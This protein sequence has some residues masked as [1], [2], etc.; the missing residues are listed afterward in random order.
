[1]IRFLHSSDLHL[2]KPFGRFPEDVRGRLKQARHDVIGRLAQ[3]ARKGGASAVLLAGDTFDAETPAPTVVRQALNEIAQANDLQ[4]VIMPGN[5]DSLAASE[6]WRTIMQDKPNNVT[7]ALTPEPLQISRGVFVLP[8][9]CTAR[10]P[11]RDLTEEMAQPTPEGALRIG[12]G[13]G[14]I[15]DFSGGEATLSEDGGAAIIPPDRAERSGLDYLALGD[16]HGQ[17]EVGKRTW[18]SG[19]PER[20]SFKHQKQASANLVILN[21]P[22]AQ[23]VVTTPA[24]GVI[25]WLG[26][27]LDL[28]PED[29]CVGQLNQNLPDVNKRRDTI[30]KITATGRIG[31]QDKTG[32]QQAIA[33]IE[34][35]FLSLEQDLSHLRMTHDT[36]DLD[37]I[38]TAG[39][40]RSAG[41]SLAERSQDPVLSAEDQEIAENALSM[42]FSFAAESS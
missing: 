9:P 27:N 38:D 36:A 22:R 28:M 31:L 15:T 16:W 37:A 10:N 24:T 35:D 23:P 19:S 4:W 30:A 21:G 2:G 39:A 29:D 6:L 13:H 42:L 18:F 7:L 14:G 8:A 34:P 32:L 20:D 40:L 33:R 5:H 3:A 26:L 25:D 11:G 41:Q 12:L 17:I 1:M